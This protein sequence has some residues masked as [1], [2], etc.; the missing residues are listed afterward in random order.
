MNEAMLELLESNFDLTFSKHENPIFSCPVSELLDEEKMRSFLKLYNPILKGNDPSVAEVYAAGW[1][2]G[3]MLGLLYMLSAWDKTLNLSLTNL[4]V[5][6]YM[7]DYNGHEYVASNLYLNDSAL[8]SAPEHTQDEWVKDKIIGFFENTVLPVFESIA[9]VGTLQVGMLWGQLPTSLAYGYDR[10]MVMNETEQV[11]QKAERN[12]ELVKSLDPAVFGRNKN[13]LNVKFRM[14]ESLDSPDK[15]MRLKSSCC[16]YYHVEGGYYCYSC[17]R[18]K[19]SEREE[20][21]LEYRAKQQA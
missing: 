7:A 18:I 13:P 8:E 6:I 16:L 20:R 19:E 1:F 3:P 12:F 14:T 11:K 4:T 9:T 17:P 21:R 10:L 15:Q 5:Q 2:R